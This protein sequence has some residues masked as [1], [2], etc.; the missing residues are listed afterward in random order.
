M[1]VQPSQS[2]P[3]S[4]NGPFARNSH[5]AQKNTL[6]DRKRH[7]GARKTKWLYIIQKTYMNPYFR[8]PT[9]LF[10]IQQ[11]DG[12]VQKMALFATFTVIYAT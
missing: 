12:F 9:M 3:A 11:G 7:R 10:A 6:L 4:D 2:N 8:G 5:M 1:A